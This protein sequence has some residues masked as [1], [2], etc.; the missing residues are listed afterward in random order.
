MYRTFIVIV[1]AVYYNEA[2]PGVLSQ[3]IPRPARR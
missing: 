3:R 1:L 2:E